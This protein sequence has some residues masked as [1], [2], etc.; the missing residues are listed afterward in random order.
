MT[1]LHHKVIG[2]FLQTRHQ[3]YLLLT[4]NTKADMKNTA[5]WSGEMSEPHTIRRCNGGL[6]GNY[7]I[8]KSSGHVT[9]IQPT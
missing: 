1:S 8:G 6:C 2:I 9:M 7:Y 3:F 4:F 5:V